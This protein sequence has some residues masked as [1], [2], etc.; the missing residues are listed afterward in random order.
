[1]N[2]SSI[3]D[4]INIPKIEFTAYICNFGNKI[5]L[6][7]IFHR[8]HGFVGVLNGKAEQ[9]LRTRTANGANKKL[10]L[11]VRLRCD[12]LPITIPG[13]HLANEFDVRSELHEQVSLSAVKQILCRS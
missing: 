11:H 5:I 7:L 13:S 6:Y 10:V 8:V 3:H 2:T 12:S 1:M 9:P 4:S